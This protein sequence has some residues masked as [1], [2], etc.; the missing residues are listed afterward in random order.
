MAAAKRTAEGVEAEIVNE[1]RMDTDEVVQVY[2]QNEG[3]AHAPKNP[4]LCAFKRVRV[5]AGKTVAV[6]LAI[7]PER[8]K[9][10]DDNGNRVDEGAPVF[11]VGLGQPD[12][13]TEALT[14]HRAVKV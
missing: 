2:A 6:K 5:P 3:A 1:G 8:L 11:W 13:R 9:V 12:G 14:G 7:P 10:V 4:R